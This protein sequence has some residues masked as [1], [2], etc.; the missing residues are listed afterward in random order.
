MP[1]VQKLDT[2]Y[3]ALTLNL[4]TSTFGSFADIGAGQ[5]FAPK[6]RANCVTALPTLA[7]TSSTIPVSIC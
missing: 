5:G 2:R 7:A 3:K 1:F 6:A 4:D